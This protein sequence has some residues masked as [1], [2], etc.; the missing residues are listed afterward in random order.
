MSM[1]KGVKFI[2]DEPGY[3]LIV[4][5]YTDFFDL[6]AELS[7]TTMF[8]YYSQGPGMWHTL[9]LAIKGE[10]EG[11]LAFG[12]TKSTAKP[13]EARIW[14]NFVSGPGR[15]ELKSQLA[16]VIADG[17]TYAAY[18][19]FIA[20][21]YAARDLGDFNAEIADRYTKLDAF[22]A[23]KNHFWVAS[24]PMYLDSVSTTPKSIVLKRFEAYPD[25]ADRWLFLMGLEKTGLGH[26]GAWVDQVNVEVELV[27]AQAVSRLKAGDLD[28]YAFA[29]A[30]AGLRA[31]VD[32]DPN[33][34]FFT[35]TGIYDEL[36]FNPVGPIHPETGKV[37]PFAL[38]Q[39]REAMN[40]A[41]DRD[42]IVGTVMGGLA[43]PQ[44]TA[45][46]PLFADAA[47]RYPDLVNVISATYAYDFE[48]ADKLI[49]EAML[50]IPGVTRVDGKYFYL[51]PQP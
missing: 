37:N 44:Y 8:P 25:D 43:I 24:G 6:D 47:V 28:L 11:K 2:T 33:L 48:K 3:D 22:V 14:T 1:F 20:A 42:Y 23:A 46:V 17:S 51:E 50:T 15:D 4:E 35:M 12:Q 18:K 26:K 16:G 30:D 36:T 41:I 40:W 10:A 19:G 39:V 7:V 45:L 49:E 38:R 32:A 27:P 9:S 29:I 21:E 5:F 31:A 34:Y 13:E